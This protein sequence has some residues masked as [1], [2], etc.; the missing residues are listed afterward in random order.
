LA[1]AC[2]FR[3]ASSNAELG[4]PEMKL[5]II[6]GWGG[7]QRLTWTAGAAVAKRLIML[8]E[9][10]KAEEALKMGLVDKVVPQNRLK[11]E[12]DKLAQRL[13]RWEP[14]ALRQVKRAI[15]SVTRNTLES[16]LK[17]ETDHFAQLLSKKETKKRLE[18]F[19]DQG[20]KK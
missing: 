1:L 4:F 16:G 11:T 2:D 14:A 8:G 13:C 9:R 3:F 7:T 20:K 6:P 19:L 15:N 17:I 5:G 12:A 18:S 10:V